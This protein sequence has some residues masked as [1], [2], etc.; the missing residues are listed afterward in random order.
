MNTLKT[1]IL[2]ITA[3]VLTG[4]GTTSTITRTIPINGQ[5]PP[6]TVLE[7]A[8]DAA[9]FI[10]FPLAKLDKDNGLVEFQ[11]LSFPDAVESIQVRVR[12]DNK[13][14]DATFSKLSP[15]FPMS[16]KGIANKFTEKLDEQLRQKPG[17]PK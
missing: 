14:V 9:R 7:S 13:F 8:I 3:S 5:R 17:V 12:A 4:C 2:T 10:G 6:V 15:W 11:R 16:V 1:L